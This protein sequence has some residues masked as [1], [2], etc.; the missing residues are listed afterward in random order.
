MGAGFGVRAMC[1]LSD[2]NGHL[3][4][5]CGGGNTDK[6]AA[7]RCLGSVPAVSLGTAVERGGTMIGPALST[8]LEKPLRAGSGC[9]FAAT[10]QHRRQ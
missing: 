2:Q 6:K 8:L 7:Y 9:P 3:R 1:D 5:P 10:G 4:Y